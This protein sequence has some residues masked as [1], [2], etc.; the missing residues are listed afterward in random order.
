MLYT[1]LPF[2]VGFVEPK[3]ASEIAPY[4]PMHWHSWNTFCAENMVNETNM[5]QM[6]SSRSLKGLVV[7]Y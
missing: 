7:V 1:L 6:V 3:P 4:P 2:V 5:Q